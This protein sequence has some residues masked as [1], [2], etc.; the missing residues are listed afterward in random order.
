MRFRWAARDVALAVAFLAGSALL[1]AG[2]AQGRP[3]S[4]PTPTPSVTETPLPTSTP[5]GPVARFNPS[6]TP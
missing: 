4:L 3:S 5:R 6:P 1:A 2:S